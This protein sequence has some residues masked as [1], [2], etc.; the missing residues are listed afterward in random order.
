MLLPK[1]PHCVDTPLDTHLQATVELFYPSELL[2]LPLV[3]TST[4]LARI[5]HQVPP[6]AYWP[7]PRELVDANE[8]SQHQCPVGRPG[9]VTV[10]HP[11]SKLPENLL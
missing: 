11:I 8:V 10:A 3:T 6:P 4:N 2:G 7:E 9:W 5:R 1:E